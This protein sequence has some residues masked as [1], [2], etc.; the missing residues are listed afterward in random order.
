VL[1]YYAANSVPSK[2]V[3]VI[4]VLSGRATDVSWAPV[5]ALYTATQSH[6]SCW[7]FHP[8]NKSSMLLS[9][10]KQICLEQ[11]PPVGSKQNNKLPVRVF[12]TKIAK[13]SVGEKMATLVPPVFIATTE[14]KV[15]G[16][17]SSVD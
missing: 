15:L 12:Q 5:E 7:H 4:R 1:S 11:F 3:G 9:V 8:T 17:H 2:L 6:L 10:A 13:P 16:K 14:S